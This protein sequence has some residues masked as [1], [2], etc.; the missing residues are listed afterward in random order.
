MYSGAP[1]S[2][3][4]DIPAPDEVVFISL[5]ADGEAYTAETKNLKPAFT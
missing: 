4:G 2:P 5:T 3:G 1:A